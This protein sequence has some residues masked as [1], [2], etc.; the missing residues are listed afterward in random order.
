MSG[1]SPKR[2]LA[3]CTCNTCS[4]HLEFDPGNAGTTIQCPHCGI[5]TVLFIPQV[6]VERTT[7]DIVERTT[8][9]EAD[10]QGRLELTREESDGSDDVTRGLED[11]GTAF[12]FFGILGGV[13]VLIVAASNLSEGKGT[14]AAVLFVF[15][16]TALV[17][18]FVLR[19][20]FRAGAQIIRLLQ[21]ANRSNRFTGKI[22]QL[23]VRRSYVC[24]R[25]NAAALPDQTRCVSCGAEFKA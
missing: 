20:L 7:A 9:E 11:A 25:C 8:W 3:V 12:L 1:D 18:G 16:I 17:T 23:S 6:A 5:E 10:V 15:G 24:S 14:D 4:A 2:T 13:I 19:L 22:T 21:E